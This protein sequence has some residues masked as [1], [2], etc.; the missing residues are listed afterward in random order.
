A[1]EI[2]KRGTLQVLRKGL[3]DVGCHFAL[4]YPQPSSGLND[5]TLR[6]CAAN[7]FTVI[8]QLHYS[9]ENENSLDLTLCLNGL[10]LFTAELKTSLTGQNVQDAMRQYA[11]DRDPR[12]PLLAFERCLAHFALD[13]DLAY[14]TT[15]LDG[16]KTRFLPFNQGRDGGAGNPPALTTYP[17]AYLWEEIWAP[18]SVL[19]LVQHFIHPVEVEDDRG[20]KTGE[21]RMLFPRY[22]QLDCVRRLIADAREHGPGRRYLIQHSA[23]SGK[24]NSIAWLAHQLSVLHDAEDRRVFDSI[25]VITDRRILDKQLQATVRQFEQ[26][27]GIVENID[28]TSRQLKAAL[29]HGKQIVVTTLQKFPVIA[30]QI[31]DLPGQRFAVIVDEAHS[32][33][34]GE[35]TKSM[36]AVLE[37]RSLEEAE[38]EESGEGEDLEDRIVAEMRRRGPQPNLSTF[39]FTATPKPKTLEL[40]G[41]C[42]PDGKYEAFSLYTMRQ[43]IE[44][45]F[46]LDV[47][48]NYTTYHSYWQL[49]KKVEDDPHY[50]RQKAKSLLRNF[51]EL[52]EQNIEKKIAVM[53]EHF[54]TST[55]PRIGGKAKAMIVTRSRLHAV[56][57][58]LVLDRHLKEHQYPYKAL[59]AFS[60]TVHDYEADADYTETGMNGGILESQTADAFNH[61]EYRFLV[62]AEKFQTGF[63]QPLLHTMY[64]DRKLG[65]VHAVQ[66]LSRL[67]RTHP[68]K[69]ETMVL[70]FANDAD[71]IK[72]AF[73]PYYDRTILREGTD[74]NL[75]YEKQ[76]LLEDYHL[77]GPEDLDRFAE[78][79]FDPT[80]NQALL[81]NLLRP[82]VDRFEEVSAEEQE[83][84]R[85]ELDGYVRLYAFLAQ[86]IRFVDADLEKLYVF[87]RYVLRALPTPEN[88]LPLEIQQQV[89]M[90]S[91]RLQITQRA[92]P[93]ELKRGNGELEPVSD[94]SRGP[95]PEGEAEA[96]SL[97]IKELND[98]FGLNWGGEEEGILTD[99]QERLSEDGALATSVQINAPENARLTFEHV[100]NDQLQGMVETHFKFYKQ[101]TD[102][103]EVGR[104]LL[105]Q[106]FARYL[107]E[108]RGSGARP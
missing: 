57:Y 89:D 33:Q 32:S 51:V 100:A 91:Y 49:L 2:S 96:L 17:T 69:D 62:V 76:G 29:E 81:G 42:R 82:A 55:A 25:I 107:T 4:Y 44:E 103:P 12:E 106:L 13:P 105:D 79:Y 54:A 8:R 87:G 20:R 108:L 92:K 47:L 72:K 34:S 102:D 46:I 85:S 78:A 59:V 83:G 93:I 58:K 77:Y 88:V 1:A 53:V 90:D 50:D 39:A 95:G 45:G 67:N 84:F 14:M 52:R 43:A 98:R 26:T 31:A 22:H 86:I 80:P 19:N 35:S 60:G 97:I 37:A 56:R 63:D 21:R 9:A 24:S 11:H 66:T 71:E 74:P 70:D 61:D 73:E 75:L 41:T 94:D 40:F 64:V 23:G 6:L 104:W 65:G 3:K 16:P 38:A 10:P 99:L 101:V 28:R 5:E 15:K 36:K 7:Q 18:A 48:Q 68:G 27:L 30:D